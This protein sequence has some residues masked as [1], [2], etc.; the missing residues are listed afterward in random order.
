M[1]NVFC[2]LAA[3]V[4]LGRALGC[5][6]H[7]RVCGPRQTPFR[8]VSKRYRLPIGAVDLL[9]PAGAAVGAFGVCDAGVL[10]D[11][12]EQVLA[13]DELERAAPEVLERGSRVVEEFRRGVGHGRDDLGGAEAA[14]VIEALGDS[15]KSARARHDELHLVEVEVRRV[16]EVD[17]VLKGKER[18][19]RRDRYQRLVELPERR[20]AGDASDGSVSEELCEKGEVVVVFATATELWVRHDVSGGVDASI[21]VDEFVE[22]AGVPFGVK[23]RDGGFINRVGEVLPR[24]G[25]VEDLEKQRS[26]DRVRGVSRFV[27]DDVVEQVLA[28]SIRGAVGVR[29]P[30]A[31]KYRVV[32]PG[33]GLVE[34]S[35]EEDFLAFSGEFP[36][37]PE[38][39]GD[40]YLSAVK[41]DRPGAP[42]GMIAVGA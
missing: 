27:V 22:G 38:H 3:V 39:F 33:G 7:G 37:R 30:V 41:P 28:D 40:D 8:G 35:A 13:V 32:G 24:V 5:E 29:E 36:V 19:E 9:D 21:V 18:S 34:S 17:C 11:L 6:G 25:A 1:S 31:L 15:S 12:T 16:V 2:Q 4:V 23:G 42:W 20:G 10:V 26:K 14:G